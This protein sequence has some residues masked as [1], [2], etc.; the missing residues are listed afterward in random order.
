MHV[1]LMN[2]AEGAQ[3]RPPRRAGP[4]TGVAVHFASAIS[5]VITCP[6]VDAMAHGGMSRM[7]AVIALPFI[8][9]QDRARWRDI[10]G[11]Q[12]SAR[13][14]VH[15]VTHP[16]ALLPRLARDHTDYGWAII[17]IGA[18]PLPFIR[19][20]ACWIAGITMRRTFFPRRSGR[21]HLPQRRCRPSHRWVR[22]RSRWLGCA[23]AAYG[24]AC[25][26]YPIPARGVPWTSPWQCRAATGPMSPGAVGFSQRPSRLVESSSRRRPDNDKLEN[27]LVLGI[28]AV[29]SAYSAGIADHAEG[30]DAP[31][32]LCRCCHPVTRRWGKSIM[33]LRYHNQHGIYTGAKLFNP[34]DTVRFTQR[35]RRFRKG[36]PV[37]PPQWQHEVAAE[38][39]TEANRTRMTG[40][41][42]QHHFV[43]Q[44][45][46]KGWSIDGKRVWMYRLLI[47]ANSVPVWR[48][49]SIRGIVV[50]DH[51]TIH[52]AKAVEQW[53]A[54]H[55][56]FLRLWLPTY[57]AP[58]PAN[59]LLTMCMT[60]VPTIIRV[61]AP[62]I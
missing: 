23:A 25:V 56:R 35:W 31:A 27:S 13:T 2:P 30:G 10:R 55:P 49:R 36:E 43:P 20:S 8:C 29:R 7:A 12:V 53:L 3:I 57:G 24:A 18:V 5:I 16:Q 45:Y 14:P 21:V 26:I 50:V 4:F 54:A 32:R 28:G 44:G 37:E 15:M 61:N 52:H 41:T 1:R 33:A 9:V 42:E 39:R 46:L 17:G 51:Q 60:G 22:S 6:F 34:S 11:D 48:K 47:S 59:V 58:S 62:E 40:I 38:I 19:A